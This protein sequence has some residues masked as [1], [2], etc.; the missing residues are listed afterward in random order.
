MNAV[1]EIKETCCV[2]DQAC[3]APGN[4]KPPIF[5]KSS[6]FACGSAV[7]VNCS[8]RRNYPPWKKVRLC[9]DCQIMHLDNGKDT[10]VM[11]RLRKLVGG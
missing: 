2:A 10:I 7:C 6:C 3:L 4:L 8:S 11:K 1:P 5:P 9:N